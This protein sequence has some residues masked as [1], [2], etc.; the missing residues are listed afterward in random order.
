MIPA[1]DAYEERERERES[2]RVAG[3]LDLRVVSL[4]RKGEEEKE[5][6]ED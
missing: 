3:H 6:E 5:S 1:L 2:E 4:S